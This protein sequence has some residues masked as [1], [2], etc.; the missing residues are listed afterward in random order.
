[1]YIII[2]NLITQH[3]GHYERPD[4]RAQLIVNAP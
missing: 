3:E 2:H 4:E 1:M